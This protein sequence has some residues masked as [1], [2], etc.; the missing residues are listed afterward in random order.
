MLDNITSSIK[1]TC[2]DNSK[3]INNLIYIID[4]LQNLNSELKLNYSHRINNNYY[5]YSINNLDYLCIYNIIKFLNSD[6]IS[7]INFAY[8][9]KN[10]YNELYHFILFSNSINE[11]FFPPFFAIKFDFPRMEND[12]SVLNSIMSSLSHS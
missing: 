9:S 5:N 10:F 7:I 12:P 6:F 11:I 4:F 3:N 2:L 1:K 8:T